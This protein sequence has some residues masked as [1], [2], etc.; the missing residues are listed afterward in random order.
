MNKCVFTIAGN[1]TKEVVRQPVF[2]LVACGGMALIFLSFSFTL[3]AF[4]EE[5]RMIKEMGVSTITVC[6]LC[7]ASLSAANTISKEIEKGTIV[8]LLSK[9][10]DKN[11]ILLGKFLGIL[12]SVSLIFIAMSVF[13]TFSLCVMESFE[14]RAGLLTSFVRVGYST[15]S[16]LMF[17]FLPIAIMCAIATAASVFLGMISNLSCCLAVYVFGHLIS[18]FQGMHQQ[19][20]NWPRWYLMPFFMLFP[21]LEEFGV[22]G[23]ED[24]GRL[25]GFDHVVLVIYAVLY[26]TF[27]L[28]LAFEFFDKK[29]CR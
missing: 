2:Y 16:Q 19:S 1:A 3:F 13:L 17:S 9:P 28:V 11:S 4:G 24:K 10:V 14:Y 25:L 8:T 23:A 29:E 15:V 20:G 26:I 22:I 27:V 21:N 7:L 18:F 5:S 12:A 6:C